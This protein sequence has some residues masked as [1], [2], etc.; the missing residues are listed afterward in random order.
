M[1][2]N[3]G[4]KQD[5]EVYHWH[6]QNFAPEVR[7]HARFDS[8]ALQTPTEQLAT[9]DSIIIATPVY[10]DSFSGG[11]KTLLDLLPKPVPNNKVILPLACG[12]SIDHMLAVNYAVLNVLK[13]QGIL[14]GVFAEDSQA[15]DYQHKPRLTPDLKQRLDGSLNLFLQA[16]QQR[17][18]NVSDLLI[19]QVIT[20][21]EIKIAS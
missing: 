14:H 10:K 11:L 15:T 20:N 21:N 5:V 19:R 8:L 3:S 13:A 2:N 16:L 1:N 9:A 6:L 17:K 7:L 4:Q 12:G 18:I